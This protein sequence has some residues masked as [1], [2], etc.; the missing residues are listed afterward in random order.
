MGDGNH[1]TTSR[2]SLLYRLER[3]TNLSLSGRGIETTD[4]L[5]VVNTVAPRSVFPARLIDVPS[6]DSSIR[7]VVIQITH[8][9]GAGDK[10]TIRPTVIP[11]EI[12]RGIRPM[13]ENHVGI[14]LGTA[15]LRLKRCVSGG[16]HLEKRFVI[17]HSRPSHIE[18]II[19]NFGDVLDGSRD[20][21]KAMSTE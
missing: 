17:G 4:M 12:I 6:R 18:G 19:G 1:A 8:V 2:K 5:P 9:V 3:V 16:G 11:A 10:G 21:I 20:L 15:K 7:G 13:T 14:D